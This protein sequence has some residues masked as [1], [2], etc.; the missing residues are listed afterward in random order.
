MQDQASQQMLWD[1]PIYY[2][3]MGNAAIA[4]KVLCDQIGGPIAQ[5]DMVSFWYSA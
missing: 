4:V 2:A 5:M 3:F 1:Q